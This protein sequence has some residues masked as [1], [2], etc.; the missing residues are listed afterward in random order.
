[1]GVKFRRQVPIGRFIVDF[2]SFGCRLVIEV[3]GHHHQPDVDARRDAWI[4]S[5]GWRAERFWT[6]DVFNDLEMVLDSIENLIRWPDASPPPPPS[7][8]THDPA[9]A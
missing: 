3:D 9:R 2:A 1:M 8:V 4:K 7:G 6:G 5:R